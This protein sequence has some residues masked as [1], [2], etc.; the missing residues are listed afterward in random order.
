V[1]MVIGKDKNPSRFR[2]VYDAVAREE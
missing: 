1:E 2:F